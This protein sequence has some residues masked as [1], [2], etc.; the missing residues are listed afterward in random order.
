VIDTKDTYEEKIRELIEP[1]LEAEGMELILAECLRMKTRWV[2]RLYIDKPEGVTIDDCSDVSHLV[3]DILDVHDLPPAAYTLEVSSPGLNRP[4]VKDQDFIKYRGRQVTVKTSA[5]IDGVRNFRGVL[6][7][8]ID[9]GG[10]KALLL[11]VGGKSFTIQREMVQSA[12]L[13]Y[14]FKA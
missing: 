14:D 1:V 2:V 11:E 10:K 5:K 6:A 8:Y 3:G 4:L 12:H 13:E 9:E 7:D